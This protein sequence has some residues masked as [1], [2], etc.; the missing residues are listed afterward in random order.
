M[1]AGLVALGGL[2]ISLFF[3]EAREWWAE[4]LDNIWEGILYFFSFQWISDVWEFVGSAFENLNEISIYGI[5]FALVGTGV[6]FYVRDYMIE[7]FV[8]YYSPMGRISWTIATYVAVAIAGYLLGKA[9]EN[10]A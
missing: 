10:T 4:Q 9:F 8:K 2:V 1:I 5:A 3:E 7:P 6:I